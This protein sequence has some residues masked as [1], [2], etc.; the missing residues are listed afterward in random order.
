MLKKSEVIFGRNLKQ[1]LANV[2]QSKT[3]YVSIYV[4][5]NTN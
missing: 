2:I 3:F 1:T 5:D 4:V